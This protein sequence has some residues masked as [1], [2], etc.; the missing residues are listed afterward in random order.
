VNQIATAAERIREVGELLVGRAGVE[1][2]MEV[3]DIGTGTGNA[4]LPAAKAGARVIGLDASAD[5]LAIA[6]ERAADAMVEIDWVEGSPDTLPFDDASFD[7]VLT[8]FG[9]LFEAEPERAAAEL[10]RVCRPGGAIGL[11]AWAEEGIAGRLQELLGGP[12]AQIA[13]EDRTLTL[14]GSERAYRLAV[15]KL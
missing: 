11:C 6:R 8:V 1:P 10:R 12:D 2:G 3:L 13:L 15:V 7:R 4:A 5:L 14:D 9:H